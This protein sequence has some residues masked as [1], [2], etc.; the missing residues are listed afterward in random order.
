MKKYSW[1]I[2]TLCSPFAT[3]VSKAQG[4]LLLSNLGQASSGYGAVASNAWI[5]ESFQTGSHSSGYFLNSIQLLMANTSSNAFGITVSVYEYKNGT[6]F[7]GNSLGSLNGNDPVGNGLY[8]YT[9]SSISLSPLTGY[10]VVLSSSTPISQGSFNWSFAN[11][12]ITTAS[13][14]WN[15][16][17]YYHTSTDG[18]NWT[19]IAGQYFQLGVYA[20]PVPEPATTSLVAIGVIT[21][22]FCRR[23][24]RS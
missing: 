13:D 3:S 9:A 6:L 8:N 10:F 16:G 7:P 24:T 14:R 21:L 15:M 20:T 4:T 17:S 19:R 12:G 2:L 1:L 11:P 18:L 23:M 22:G 5:A